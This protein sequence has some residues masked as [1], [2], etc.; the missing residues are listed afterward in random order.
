MF[1]KRH[2]GPVHYP[3]LRPKR[4][5]RGYI[6]DLSARARQVG[7][8]L[9]REAKQAGIYLSLILALGIVLGSLS[10]IAFCLLNTALL[11]YLVHLGLRWELALL[12]VGGI[13]LLAAAAAGIG[14]A[15]ISRRVDFSETRERLNQS[16]PPSTGDPVP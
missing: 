10:V 5:L 8:E 3:I 13:Y 14:M 7:Q 9:A 12:I 6:D 11:L 15:V 4:F 16:L 1:F 2:Q